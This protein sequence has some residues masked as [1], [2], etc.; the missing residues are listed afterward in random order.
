M[1]AETR[2][3]VVLVK[4]G[5]YGEETLRAIGCPQDWVDSVLGASKREQAGPRIGWGHLIT[6]GNLIGRTT[7]EG[8][9]GTSGR[10][11]PDI[12]TT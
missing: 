5:A 1:R 2:T 11:G 10:K 6:T 3:T 8:S 9:G 12:P 7:F 4:P